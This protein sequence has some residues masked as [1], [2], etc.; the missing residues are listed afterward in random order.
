MPDFDHERLTQLNINE[1]EPYAFWTWDAGN[2]RRGG[3][4]CFRGRC[5]RGTDGEQDLRVI[6]WWMSEYFRES[7]IDALVVDTWE[8]GGDWHDQLTFLPSVDLPSTFSVLYSVL[9]YRWDRGVQLWGDLVRENLDLAL[10]ET[11]RYLLSLDT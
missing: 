9:P 4:V 2:G 5:R 3:M 7:R 6:D 10:E 8:F 1:V 11:D